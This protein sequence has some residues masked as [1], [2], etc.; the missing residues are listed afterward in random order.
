MRLATDPAG[1]TIGAGAYDAWG[2]ARPYTGGSGAT[3]LAGLQ[4]VAPFGY[5]GQQRDA[6]PGTYAMRARRYDPTQG[7]FQSQDPARPQPMRPITL[8]PYAYAWD[9]PAMR[10][11]PSGRVPEYGFVCSRRSGF[12]LDSPVYL[13]IDGVLQGHDLAESAW[14]Q[15]HGGDKRTCELQIPFGSRNFAQQLRQYN[16]YKGK[17]F[18]GYA[19]VVENYDGGAGANLY[20]FEPVDAVVKQ[21][22][23]LDSASIFGKMK[24]A[25]HYVSAAQNWQ[26][27]GGCGRKDVFYFDVRRPSH[28]S[29]LDPPG[30][31]EG[32][33]WS[34]PRRFVL[35]PTGAPS[36]GFPPIWR[37]RNGLGTWYMVVN[38]AVRPG[39]VL[40]QVFK[41]DLDGEARPYYA[42][43]HAPATAQEL[44]TYWAQRFGSLWYPGPQYNWGRPSGACGS[45]N[46]QW[47]W[48]AAGTAIKWVGITALAVGAT[49]LTITAIGACVGSVVCGV[50]AAG[51]AIG[52][53][54]V[55]AGP[56]SP[57]YGTAK[58][59]GV[60]LV[61]RLDR[62]GSDA[63][64]PGSST[65]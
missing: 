56:S 59:A 63:P 43:D 30:P 41:K 31:T 38:E 54:V 36:V 65:A 32:T 17:P 61:R 26:A 50:A 9:A 5:A 15:T 3:Q 19:D 33:K 60:T 24:E 21:G 34:K 18:D 64:S 48:A 58:A 53:A 7:R 57:N 25:D 6:G 51:I 35:G 16:P 39:L 20:E 10:S 27:I 52:A 12:K 49:T 40:F 28:E 55:L 13:N 62:S 1:A 2:N 22:S 8:D 46:C 29:E 11:D 23:G 42:L 37:E 14:L 4:G 45:G 47:G 44:K